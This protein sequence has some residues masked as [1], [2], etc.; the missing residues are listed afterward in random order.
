MEDPFI[1]NGGL[2]ISFHLKDKY[3]LCFITICKIKMVGLT[4]FYV[5]SFVNIRL[6]FLITMSL[7]QNFSTAIVY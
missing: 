4:I 5:L 6:C 3:A 7:Y 1:S 2:F